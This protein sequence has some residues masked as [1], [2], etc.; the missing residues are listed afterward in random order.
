VLL[1]LQ[2][3]GSRPY[4]PA[5]GPLHRVA[6]VVGTAVACAGLGLV[7]IFGPG[8]VYPAYLGYRHHVLSAVADQQMGGA[9]LWVIALVP[10][11]VTAVALLIRWLNDEESQDLAAGIDRLLRPPKSAWPSRPGLR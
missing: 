5:L 4:A 6:L 2:L 9:V 3:I 1:W 10:F 11:G 7:R 8:L